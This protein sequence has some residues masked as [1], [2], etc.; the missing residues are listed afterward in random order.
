MVTTKIP[1]ATIN[2]PLYEGWNLISIPVRTAD[3]N[4]ESILSSIAGKYISVWSYNNGW[5]F[6]I[7]D[8]SLKSKA[9][10][11]TIEQG[12][13]YWIKMLS[14]SV[15][16]ITGKILTNASKE[17]GIGWNLIGCKS[18]SAKNIDKILQPISDQI[19]SAWGYDSQRKQWLKYITNDSSN[20]LEMIEP[21]KGY[22]LNVKNECILDFNT[23]N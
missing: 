21:G 8:T 16:T 13:G 10:I 11:K 20:N 18:I 5:N 17:L 23:D 4:I 2:I 6:S 22:W 19:I 12:F 3:N 7:F 15:L 1:I 9:E 14:D